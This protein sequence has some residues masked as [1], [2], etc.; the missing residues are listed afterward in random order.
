[1][2]GKHLE[3]FCDVQNLENGRDFPLNTPILREFMEADPDYFKITSL[4]DRGIRYSDIFSTRTI[5]SAAY[6]PQPPG[7]E[8]S[9]EDIALFVRQHHGALNV[10]NIAQ[11]KGISVPETR[12]G[13][14][15]EGVAFADPAS[16]NLVYRIEYLAGD[17]VYAKL[18]AART[19]AATDPLTFQHNVEELEKIIP[20]K[21]PLE[22]LSINSR[23]PIYDAALLQAFLQD[24]LQGD[25]T[26]KRFLTGRIE[27]EGWSEEDSAQGSAN[28]NYSKAFQ[29]Y[30]N[31]ETLRVRGDRADDQEMTPEERQIL[32]AKR[33]AQ[34]EFEQKTSK[35]FESWVKDNGGKIIAIGEREEPVRD[36]VER[37]YNRAFNRSV[38]PSHDG[39]RLRFHGIAGEMNG[40]PLHLHKH[41]LDFAARMLFEGRGG[42]AHCVG[43]GKT[44]AGSLTVKA[45]KQ[46]GMVRKPAF[47]VPKKVLEKWAKEYTALFPG[48]HVMVIDRF[49]KANREEMLSRIAVSSPDAIFMTHEHAKMIPNDS[50]IETALIEEELATLRKQLFEAE[51]EDAPKRTLRSIENSIAKFE[52][53]LTDLREFA[54]TNRITFLETGI[55]AIIIDEAHNY[56]NLPVQATEQA[57]G[58]PSGSSQRAFDLYMKTRQVL[59]AHRNR[60]VLLLTATPVSNTM[61]EIYNMVKFVAPEAWTSRGIRSFDNWIDMFGE[62][63]TKPQVLVDGTFGIRSS[64]SSFK[65]LPELKQIF[66]SFWEARTA[67]QLQLRRPTAEVVVR[68]VEPSPDQSR[69]FEEIVERAEAIRE[70]EVEPEFDN[71]LKLTVD[72]RKAALDM[73]LVDP[74]AYGDFGEYPDSKLN[75]IA[76]EIWSRYDEAREHG[77]EAGQLVFFDLYAVEA[78]QEAEV[79]EERKLEGVEVENGG[80][81]E[82]QFTN[83]TAPSR[84]AEANG[85]LVTL[86][87][88]NEL[89]R[90][91]AQRGIPPEEI[92]IL[93]GR[94]NAT[95]AAKQMVSDRYNEGKLRVVIGT[96]PAMG[97][98]MNLQRITTAI[99]HADVPLKPSHMEQRDG[100]GLRQG[101]IHKQMEILRYT[102]RGSFDQY[103]Y[104]LL[105]RK[106]RF[107]GMFMSEQRV[108]R[109]VEGAFDTVVLSYEEA[110]GATAKDPRIRDYFVNKVKLSQAEVALKGAEQEWRSVKFHLR[111]ITGAVQR[112]DE[113][114]ARDERR[115][116]ERDA[117]LRELLG[118][119]FDPKSLPNSLPLRLKV[120]GRAVT[121]EKEMG[122]VLDGL[123]EKRMT[124][125]KDDPHWVIAVKKEIP[126]GVLELSGVKFASRMVKGVEFSMYDEDFRAL[127]RHGDVVP[128][129]VTESRSAVSQ[130]MG[131]VRYELRSME[132]SVELVKEERA[133][134]ESNQRSGARRLETAEKNLTAARKT[135]EEL[136]GKVQTLS[137]E[138]GVNGKGKRASRDAQET[139]IAPEEIDKVLNTVRRRFR[140]PAKREKNIEMER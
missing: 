85:S 117:I 53:R 119:R 123:L 140:V 118:Q 42:N 114:L 103:L 11:L 1:L 83:E 55:D 76:D 72:G 87:L 98:G 30:A 60:G 6:Q 110:M 34:R 28:G 33:Q 86:D 12:E 2:V 91:L 45:W 56:K 54:K 138:I 95:A 47:I 88:H 80:E 93:N 116:A 136:R 22:E 41:N 26:V 108:E 90:L 69:Y 65:N 105:E 112:C 99:H 89:A 3:K 134:L 10:E 120:N 102:T 14:L 113:R 74:V 125:G 32:Q 17:D 135:C 77:V 49:D 15:K 81:P 132:R 20:K 100:R 73:R 79:A 137:A 5:F 128:M 129:P 94:R 58:I 50:K 27:V 57:A 82:E 68:V 31:R 63:V 92:A 37:V 124:G 38:S 109:T 46:S 16:G 48:D 101:N 19:K 7:P 36:Y 70:K 8:A 139:D 122:V 21:I 9:L 107:I 18:D 59:E 67:E 39:T 78:L 111:E 121:D 75:V 126:G 104:Q 71:M 35:D 43:A 4:V 62:I 64:L 97:E 133:N 61:A 96:T 51:Q 40:Q 24:R 23:Q 25:F 44:F 127:V 130:L 66:E 131:N 29:A 84:V 115:L 52:N 106:A 13:L